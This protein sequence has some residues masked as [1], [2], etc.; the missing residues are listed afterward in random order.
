MAG[1][2]CHTPPTAPCHVRPESQGRLLEL[3]A[4][5]FEK[6]L[7]TGARAGRA[8]VPALERRGETGARGRT[9]QTP[10]SGVRRRAHARA[11]GSPAPPFY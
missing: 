1:W 3:H 5:A 9:G 11:G 10:G 4:F 7:E 8:P 6:R 2:T